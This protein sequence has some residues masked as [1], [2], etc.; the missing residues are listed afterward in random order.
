M[1]KVFLVIWVS[2]MG[3]GEGGGVTIHEM[4]NMEICRQVQD[5]VLN[6]KDW[7]G[8]IWHGTQEKSKETPS[9]ELPR[10]QP[11]YIG[12]KCIQTHK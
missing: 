6:K 2:I 10:M 3:F 8:I 1:I 9:N 7:K 12:I 5:S 4:P 11:P